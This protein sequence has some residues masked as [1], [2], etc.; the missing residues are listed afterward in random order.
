MSIV[1]IEVQHDIQPNF[2]LFLGEVL[3]SVTLIA[4][5][6]RSIEL[7]YKRNISFDFF[8]T[9]L[10]NNTSKIDNFLASIETN[11]NIWNDCESSAFLADNIMPTIALNVEDY[12]QNM[13]LYN[14]LVKY[15][16][17]VI[18]NIGNIFIWKNN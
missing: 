5:A 12:Y 11:K 14:F 2:T 17:A 7:N 4:V 10:L 13:N 1:Y 8:Y 16:Q 9:I 6:S 3:D 15:K 18:L